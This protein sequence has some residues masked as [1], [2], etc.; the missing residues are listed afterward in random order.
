MKFDRAGFPFIAAAVVPAVL[1][2]FEPGCEQRDVP[3]I[4]ARCVVG[5]AVG[6]DLRAACVRVLLA[7]LLELFLDHA[8]KLL[9]ALEQR[10]EV[11]DLRDEVLLLG[12][13]LGAREPRQAP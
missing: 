9:G 5:A 11:L 4:L 13:E 6:L 1:L 3:A 8:A 10:V 12:V 2:A 7:D